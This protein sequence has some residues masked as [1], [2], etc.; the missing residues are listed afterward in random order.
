MQGLKCSTERRLVMRRVVVSGFWAISPIGITPDE[1]TTSL[2]NGT[3]AV[4][5]SPAYAELNFGSHVW[6]PV[7]A[8]L[9][10]LDRAQLRFMGEGDT[11]LYGY[12]AMLGAVEN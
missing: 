10:K 7:T 11:L 1:I 8:T 2:E 5:S 6:A 12:L 3:S 9:P 4:I